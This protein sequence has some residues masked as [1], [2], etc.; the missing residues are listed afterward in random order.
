VV[1]IYGIDTS[2]AQELL[3]YHDLYDG[4]I[5]DIKMEIAKLNMH[6]S[7]SIISEL[8]N[9]REYKIEVKTCGL[10]LSFPFETAL[11]KI[12]LGV[13]ANSSKEF[14]ENPLL[15]KNKHI[16]SLQ[17][18][19]ILLKKVI[20]YGDYSSLTQTD[21]T[22]DANDYSNIIRLQLIVTE[23][24][25]EDFNKGKIDINHFIYGN[26]HL[27]YD[28]NVA[29]Q[30]ARSYYMLEKLSR[31]KSNFEIDIQG[32]YR[33][34]YGDFVKQYKYTPTQYLSLLFWELSAY[35]PLKNALTYNSIWRNIETVYGK[36]AMIEVGKRVIKDL[37][38]KP[39]YYKEWAKN[40]ESEMWDFSLFSGCPF[41]IDYKGAYISISEHTLKNAFFEKLYWKIRDC[42]S[43]N[44]SRAMSFYG[45]LFE[46]YIQD[47]TQEAAAKVDTFDYIS[48]FKYGNKR[49]S[50]AY[51]R[52]GDKLLIVE[53]KGYSI[54][55]SSLA[56][57]VN[58]EKNNE[59]LFIKPILQAD[60]RFDEIDQLGGY[61]DGVST[62]YILS[63]T[64]D[65]VNAVPAYLDTI[66][67]DIFA[68]KRSKKTKFF[69]N[70]NIEEYEMLMFL[71]ENGIDIFE[72]LA[73][74]FECEHILPFSTY[75]HR[76]TEGKIKMTVFMDSIYKEACNTM[77][78][79][80]EL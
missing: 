4:A 22:I 44:D 19:L 5:P 8:I 32:E 30:F 59:K 27:N 57:N 75:L 31:D 61:F 40:T 50:D 62:A 49:S 15:Y 6:K 23:E 65:S 77:K 34:Y 46:K 11:K 63:V 17:M 52:K 13:S 33:D 37:S 78:L 67:G 29:N 20:V 25:D 1:S 76:S 21:Y 53:T 26:Y 36:T 42:Y 18:F 14:F 2:N 38:Q 64:M 66:Y 39:D 70:F 12:F 80:Y 60:E 43:E 55:Q 47:L 7:I 69:Y 54:L 58:I 45:R 79:M 74:Y 3:C 16:V 73:N 68:K 28:H 51:L 71:T 48:E 9:A 41:I 35:Y 10:E 24:F 72:V 56:Q